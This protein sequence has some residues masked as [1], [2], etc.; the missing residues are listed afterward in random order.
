[1]RRTASSTSRVGWR[2]TASSAVYSRSPPGYCVWWMY[3]LSCHF[4]PVSRTFSAF[5]TTTKSPQSAWGVKVG[6]C[7]PRRTLAMVVAARPSTLS[8]TSMTTQWR[9]MVCL[10][11]IT[12]FMRPF[13]PKGGV[14]YWI[15]SSVS[16]FAALRILP[17]QERIHV[18]EEA[19]GLARL[20]LAGRGGWP[21]QVDQVDQRCFLRYFPS[22]CFRSAARRSLMRASSPDSLGS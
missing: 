18:G 3:F 12:V 1:M 16:T 6:L 21:A 7:L 15:R 5:T 8:F 19:P 14:L 2:A 22:R 13:S 4:L 20:R 9:W 17:G 10:L 11:P